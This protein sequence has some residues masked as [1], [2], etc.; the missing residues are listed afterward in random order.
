MNKVLEEL[1]EASLQIL[2]FTGVKF[3]HPEI[4]RII[5]K[6]GVKVVG[7]TAYFS[8]GDVMKWIKKVPSIFSV[9][10]RNP[11]HN[12]QLGGENTEFAAG[13]GAPSVIDQTGIKRRAIFDDYV[14]FLKMVQQSPFF[15]INGGILVQPSDVSP[16]HQFPLMLYA[17]LLYSDKCLMGGAGGAEEANT[18]LDM[19]DI[20]F[21]KES[22]VAKPRILAILNSTSPLQFDRDTLDILLLFAKY[23]Q[24][25]IITPAVMAGTTGPITL[26]GTIALSNAEILAGIAVAQMLR[27]GTPVMYGMQSTSADMKTGAIA[28]GSP[29]RAL[30]VAYG[31]RLAKK[32]GIPYRGGG[33]ETD[34]KSLSVQSGYESMMDILVACQE[35][36]NLIIH[37]AGMLD[38]HGAISYEKF[39][40]D[41]EILGMV[42]RLLQ[43][44]NTDEES[45]AVDIIKSVGPGG[46][47]LTN[48]HT[49][50]HF[51]NEQY[52][53]FV[54]L[55][56]ALPKGITPDQAL[57]SKIT[58]KREEMLSQYCQP[59]LPVEILSRIK[60]YLLLKGL[61]ETFL[62][63][64]SY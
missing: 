51:R 30:C 40:V 49:L 25:V 16:H 54:S 7:Q 14:T 59:K 46:E 63:T 6:N 9:Y 23:G 53:P 35:K 26:A 50:Q 11:E 1:H 5:Q 58:K 42:K 37:S 52:L 45:L 24:P 27:E 8:S 13:Y 20:V 18:A 3:F 39:I 34:A 31:A 48:E 15:N 47:Y 44:V 64:S 28:N 19:L 43:G 21:G 55:R 17:S 61:D 4:L 33:T 56:G 57:I 41:L 32:Y 29:E 38:S 10:A 60:E 22:L 12:I 62:A 2:E 36:T